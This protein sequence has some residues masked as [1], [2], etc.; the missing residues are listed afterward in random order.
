M[1]RK[2]PAPIFC[3]CNKTPL[4]K[5]TFPLPGFRKVSLNCPVPGITV[6][7]NCVGLVE[8]TVILLARSKAML[9]VRLSGRFPFSSRA[10][11]LV[12]W[13]RGMDEVAL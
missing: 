10:I 12:K 9:F 7:L 8:V 13:S 6:S 3:F 4:T 2:N 11:A 5:L 1:P